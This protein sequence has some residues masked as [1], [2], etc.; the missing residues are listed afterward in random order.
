MTA[1]FTTGNNTRL[2]ASHYADIHSPP[3]PFP[4]PSPVTA[5]VALCRGLYF[6]LNV[7]FIRQYIRYWLQEFFKFLS[8]S[9]NCGCCTASSSYCTSCYLGQHRQTVNTINHFDTPKHVCII[10]RV[11][12]LLLP[13]N[14]RTFQDSKNVFPQVAASQQYLNVKTNSS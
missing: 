8:N 4:L 13:K 1:L 2:P 3:S 11:P 12:T 6:R 7:L 10:T 5:V 9:Y 14:S